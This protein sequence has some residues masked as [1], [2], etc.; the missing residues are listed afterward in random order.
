MATATVTGNVR[1][2]QFVGLNDRSPELVF[3]ID[4]QLVTQGAGNLLVAEPAKVIPAANG[5]FSIELQESLGTNPYIPYKVT[6]RW[7]SQGMTRE[8]SSESWRIVVPRGGGAIADMVAVVTPSHIITKGEPGADGA[9]SP[10]TVEA[11]RAAAEAAIDAADIV[12]GGQRR[13]L[14]EVNGGPG[15]PYVHAMADAAGRVGFALKKA[16]AEAYAPGGIDTPRAGKVV[17]DGHQ[18]GYAVADS[19]GRVSEIAVG[20]DG[21]FPTST[22]SAWATRMGWGANTGNAGG[23]TGATKLAGVALTLPDSA[24]PTTTANNI[25]VR[26]PILLGATAMEWRVHIRNYNDKTSTVYPGALSFTGVRFGEHARDGNGQLSGAFKAAPASIAGPFT[27]NGAGGEWVSDWVTDRPI[28][29]QKDYLLSY[30]YTSASQPNYLAS[31]GGWTT[32]SATDVA[33]LEPVRTQVRSVPL[34]VWIEVKVA[35]ETPVIATVGD[36]LSLGIQATLPVYDSWPA[37]HA[38]ANGA[39]HSVYAIGGSQATDWVDIASRRLS[40]WEGCAKPNAVILALGNN[41]IFTY[42]VSLATMQE[43]TLAV[44]GMARSYL[45]D[46][47]Y[48][49]TILPRIGASSSTQAVWSAFNKWLLTTLP[50]G[51]RECFDFAERIANSSGD[52]DPLWASTPSNF[53]LNTAGYARCAATVTHTLA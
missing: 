2:L 20:R 26:L 8:V 49:T 42:N 12:R 53:H 35:A 50:A 3:E 15:N 29:A 9:S 13:A 17:D 19:A 52:A 7:I 11:A 4:E 46:T 48:L 24:N 39:I 41:D 14:Q 16:G 27:T 31:A 34:D 32:T 21:R 18:Y 6:V 38:V 25:N 51:A 44:A 40:K 36:S 43:R 1:D 33:A 28:K 10:V 45:A 47:V 37:K 30:G 23:A 22:L 5:A